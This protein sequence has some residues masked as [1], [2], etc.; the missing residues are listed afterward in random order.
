MSPEYGATCGFFPVDEETLTYLRLTGRPDERVALV[1][2]YCKEQGLFHDPSDA[3]TYTQVVE[4]DLDRRR[5]EPRRAAAAAGPRAARGTSRTRS[6]A[7]S[8]PSAIGY[9]N[10]THDKESP[11]RSPR[12]TRPSD[13]APG[14]RRRRR[15][16]RRAVQPA[17]VAIGRAARR[18]TP[19]RVDGRRAE[20]ELDHGAVVIAAITS[21][22]N[23]SNPSGDDRAP[24]SSRRRRSSGA[25]Q[26]KPWVKSSLA[27][28]SQGRHRLLRARGPPALPRRARLPDR[29]LRLHD[30]H[31]ELGPAPGR[32]LG[33]GRRGRPRRR[34]RPLREPELRGADPSGGEGELPRLAAARRRVRARRPDRHR[35]RRSS[36]SARTADGTDV[37]LARPLAERR[38]GPGDRRRRASSG[39]M[40][41]RAYADVFTGRRAA[42]AALPVPEG[43]LYAWDD[44]LDLRAPS[45]LLR[46]RGAAASV[47]D[48][49]GARCLVRVGDSDHDRPHL[50]RRLDQARQPGRALP[51]SS[52]AS[53]GASST[54]TARAAATTR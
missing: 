15:R 1:E 11:T 52:T 38:G 31:R 44:A 18:P 25:S 6:E 17:P 29:R 40:F 10:G 5:A 9:A 46:G 2:A 49:E 30:L 19:V 22:T 16:S 54:P 50:A 3:P 41:R 12:A 20:F 8:R 39:D 42:G 51:R 37:F 23:T 13:T 28:G 48:V 21:C 27:P 32:D 53:S 36:R 7:P 4:L 45:A 34:G 47:E 43:E 14:S 24:A 33:G 26:R 35:P